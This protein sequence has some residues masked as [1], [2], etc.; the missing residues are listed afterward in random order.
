MWAHTCIIGLLVLIIVFYTPRAFSHLAWTIRIRR[1]YQVDGEIGYRYVSYDHETTDGT[2][3]LHRLKTGPLPPVFLF[4]PLPDQCDLWVRVR[5]RRRL[6]ASP[7]LTLVAYFLKRTGRF[8]LLTGILVGTRVSHI[9]NTSRRFS[10][11]GCFV[12]TA[13]TVCNGLDDAQDLADAHAKS[14]AVVRESHE[15][16]DTLAERARMLGCDYVFNKWMLDRIEREDGKVLRL[17]RGGIRVSL[18]TLLKV[19]MPLD[20]KCVD[21]GNDTWVLMATPLWM[22]LRQV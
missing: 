16:C 10:T 19:R 5:M 14:I 13:Y 9:P 7:F 18:A 21:E 1:A 8:D 6:N 20:L 4:R 2:R 22:T 17:H 3:V 15:P 11:K 12:R